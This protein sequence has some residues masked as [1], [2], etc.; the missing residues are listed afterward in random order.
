M[1]KFLGPSSG[2]RT[3]SG[4]AAGDRGH[5][6]R[7]CVGLLMALALVGLFS[8]PSHAQ[9]PGVEISAQADRAVAQFTM[10]WSKNKAALDA[11]R[12][13]EVEGKKSLQ[14]IIERAGLPKM[15]PCPDQDKTTDER[16]IKI[17]LHGIYAAFTSAMKSEV[18]EHESRTREFNEMHEPYETRMSLYDK[19]IWSRARMQMMVFLSHI[20]DEQAQVTE[21]TITNTCTARKILSSKWTA[22]EEVLDMLRTETSRRETQEA[23]NLA[24][25][26]A[27]TDTL[28]IIMEMPDGPVGTLPV[29]VPTTTNHPR[30]QTAIP[31]S[32]KTLPQGTSLARNGATEI[33]LQNL[34][35]V[36]IIPVSINGILT[37]NFLIDSGATDVSLP[38]DVVLT[39]IRTGSL[40]DTDFLGQKTYRLADGSTVPSQTFRIRT[41]TIGDRK[42][43][44][45]TG[46]VADVKGSLLL[47]QSFLSR[48]RSWSI[49]NQRHVLV[50]E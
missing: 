36:F 23:S 25:A 31:S 33:P 5:P 50:L 22:S 30:L 38:A 39:L 15:Q 16:A 34:N 29:P 40:R 14:H 2:G 48:F 44:N 9:D 8:A 21:L 3:R 24:Q 10:T 19:I 49:D 17:N 20:L 7:I 18:D 43:E 45:V 28:S 1:V 6:M 41:L 4:P 32:P 46:S 27:F 35:G 42:I 26:N 12:A 13:R 37:L 47:G 11:L